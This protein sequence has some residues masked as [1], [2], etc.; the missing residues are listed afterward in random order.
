M[1]RHG[2]QHNM[3][4]PALLKQEQK[5][6]W[7]LGILYRHVLGLPKAELSLLQAA[8]SSSNLLASAHFMAHAQGP[9]K[10]RSG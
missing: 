5:Q 4:L 9:L 6:C 7:T 8:A 1:P 3:D 10:R 2:L